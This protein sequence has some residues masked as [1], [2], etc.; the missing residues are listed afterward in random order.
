MS[1]VVV[2]HARKSYGRMPVLD[3]LDLDIPAGSITAVLGASGSGKTT[4][5]RSIA[6]FER[7]DAGTIAIGDRVVDDGAN[8]T[9]AQHR[10]VGYVPQD[11]GLFPHLR[12]RANI[13]FGLRRRDAA[14]VA[15]LVDMLGLIGLE[16]RF[17]HQLSGGQRQRV[18]LARALAPRP[19]LVLLDEP[20]A[21]LDAALRIHLRQYVAQV[22][23]DVGAT[24][25]VVTHDR[26]EA[27]TMADQIAVLC[28]GRIAGVGSPRQLYN[29]P[30]DA[31]VARFLGAANLL[32]GKVVA[33]ELHC[34]VPIYDRLGFD[35]GA[36]TVLLRPEH[37]SVA[38][39]VADGA[40]ARVAA[41]A[42][43]GAT[44][45]LTLRMEDEPT[46]EL[47]AEVSGDVDIVV[48]QRVWLSASRCDVAWPLS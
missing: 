13:A 32:P 31:H 38:L 28:D 4:L 41:V 25:I 24:A 2:Q 30:P 14:R 45:A 47:V 1:A 34:A 23:H 39:E 16:N 17:P 26:D 3:G 40:E 46:A 12:V 9:H 19:S 18:A 11:G 21:S 6:G 20:F 27:F 36:Y 37:L 15:E 7:L 22:L 48:G 33:G 42:Y 43:Q 10:G 5:L 29:A 44:I 8:W 35:D